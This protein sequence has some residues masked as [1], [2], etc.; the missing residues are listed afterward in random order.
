MLITRSECMKKV[1][2]LLLCSCLLGACTNQVD[3]NIEPKNVKLEEKL[4]SV[5]SGDTVTLAEAVAPAVV[6]ISS[7]DSSGQSV[8][9]GVC[10]SS[11]G[12]VLTN[13]HVIANPNYIQLHL[14]N[15][16]TVS[17]SLIF[18]DSVQDVAIVKANATLPYLKLA[19]S[20]N[21]KVGEDILAVGTPISL[22]LKHTF[23]KGIVSALN[24]T[25][26]VSSLSGDAYMQN[27]IQHDA[28][29]NPGNSGG[30]LINSNGEVVGINTLKISGGEGIGFAIPSK[31]IS[32]LVGSY[33]ENINYRTPYLGVFGYD[34]EI[35]NYYQKSNQ[36]QGVYV[37]D[38]AGKS[39]LAG[40]GVKAGDVI[41]SFNGVKIN[42]MLDLRN[43]LY[44]CNYGDKVSVGFMQSNLPKVGDITL[45]ERNVNSNQ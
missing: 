16:D 19:D 29:L 33:V 31:S 4:I 45:I 20:D 7:T 37:I 41:T 8:G 39:P 18:E 9:S 5:E 21:V 13:S 44:K 40:L 38:V 36:L 2:G 1:V 22:T 26:Q 11:G 15:G 30:P 12:Y 35:A 32:S 25:L 23:T 3:A 34:A 6:G 43:E 28:S 17:A 10:I 14:Y 24:R 42:N 27:L